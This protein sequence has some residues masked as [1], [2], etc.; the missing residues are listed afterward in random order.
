MR[1]LVVHY[2]TKS[3]YSY[4]H[5]ELKNL[6]FFFSKFTTLFIYLSSIYLLAT[7]FHH[8]LTDLTERTAFVQD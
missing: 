6:L 1:H 3:T 8:D 7:Q 5:N 2:K 4:Q